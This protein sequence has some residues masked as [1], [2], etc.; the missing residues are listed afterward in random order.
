MVG[1]AAYL[2][3]SLKAARA[4]TLLTEPPGNLALSAFG[5]ESERARVC[6][7]FDNYTVFVDSSPYCL[8]PDHRVRIGREGFDIYHS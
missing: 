4:P 8:V 3:S 6:L 1:W 7:E 2:L 5:G